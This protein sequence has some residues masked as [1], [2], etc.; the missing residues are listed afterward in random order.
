MRI[1]W[2]GNGNTSADKG[3]TKNNRAGLV[4]SASR[5]YSETRLVLITTRRRQIICQRLEN[6]RKLVLWATAGVAEGQETIGIHVVGEEKTNTAS[7]LEGMRGKK[8]NSILPDTLHS[9]LKGQI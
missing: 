4:D 6:M 2:N 9:K 8:Y 3:G 5:N 1:D 7:Q